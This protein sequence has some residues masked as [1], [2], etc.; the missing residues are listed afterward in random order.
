MQINSQLPTSAPLFAY[1]TEDGSFAPMKHH[2]FMDRCAEIWLTEGLEP[3]SGHAFRIGGTT[4]LL[5]LGVDPF[6]V[7]VQGRWKSNA[8]LEYWRHCEDILPNM[9]GLALNLQCHSSFLSN[10]AAF[11][12]KLL[13]MHC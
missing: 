6:T 11:K 13:S 3:L 2:Y 7:M 10:M 8:F 9:I 1:E 5:V 4:H 12:H